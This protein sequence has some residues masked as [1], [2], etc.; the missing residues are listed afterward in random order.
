MAANSHRC[1]LNRLVMAKGAWSVMKSG[2]GNHAAATIGQLETLVRSRPHATQRR[3]D[4]SSTRHC[5][6]WPLEGLDPRH[7]SE[8][9]PAIL[10]ASLTATQGL[11]GN[12]W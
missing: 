5:R 7:A 4:L 11:C 1:I 9:R 8:W 12:H 6:P 2:L 10:S 3:I